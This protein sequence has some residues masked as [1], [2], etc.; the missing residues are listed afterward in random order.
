MPTAPATPR[1]RYRQS[2]DPPSRRQRKT[3]STWTIIRL[4]RHCGHH[5]DSKIQNSRS[6]RRNQGRRVRLRSS[7]AIWWRSAI[8]SNSNAVRVRGSF[9]TTGTVPLVGT[10]MHRRLSPAHRNHQRIGAD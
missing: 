5:R 4:S 8:P 2:A 6:I 7:T 1:D 10:A 3:V 9:R